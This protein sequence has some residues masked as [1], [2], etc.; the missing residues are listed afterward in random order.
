MIL[1]EIEDMDQY[2]REYRLQGIQHEQDWL[3]EEIAELEERRAR[4]R[5]GV[6]GEEEDASD[7]GPFGNTESK[8][9]EKSRL[10]DLRARLAELAMKVTFFEKDVALPEP[11][12]KRKK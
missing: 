8:G 1:S 2:Y 4:K 12:R 6:H 7:H 10:K 9:K 3:E 11:P 5:A